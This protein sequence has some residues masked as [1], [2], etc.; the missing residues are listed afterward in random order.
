MKKRT[1]LIILIGVFTLVYNLNTFAIVGGVTPTYEL[2]IGP[3]SAKKLA[4]AQEQIYYAYKNWLSAQNMVK[5]Q[6][7]QERLLQSL[8]GGSN[9]LKIM[10]KNWGD[11]SPEE[12][13]EVINL[14]HDLYF[15]NTSEIVADNIVNNDVV[16]Q[17][18]KGDKNLKKA[19]SIWQNETDPN[20][21]DLSEK[22]RLKREREKVQTREKK[23]NDLYKEQLLKYDDE[24]TLLDNKE[25]D[26]SKILAEYN[27]KNM[28]KGEEIIQK[29]LVKIQ[30]KF[31]QKLGKANISASLKI[32]NQLML[33]LAQTQLR[34][35]QSMN[36]LNKLMTYT[37]MN[38]NYKEL[39]NRKIEIRLKEVD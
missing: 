37:T 5:K 17:I 35:L 23:V 33:I 4:N 26:T 14:S 2:Q 7:S 11:L 27:K 9:T 30:N 29:E 32:Q 10:N 12:I 16:N 18:E 13:E 25:L 6:T 34:T 38:E 8:F 28:N 22:E 15:E 3:Y 39:N 21:R 24:L 36:D 1:I 19:I 20:N 31:N